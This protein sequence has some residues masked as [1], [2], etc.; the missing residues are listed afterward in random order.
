MRIRVAHSPDSD[1]AFMFHA[2]ANR[3]LDTGAYE[4]VNVLSDIE[5]L[6]RKALEGEYEVTAVSYHAYACVHRRYAL[7]TAGSSMG[8]NYG[9][10]IV[11]RPGAV[12]RA[13][14]PGKLVA[15]PGTLTSAF[16]ALKLFAPEARHEVIPFDRILEHVKAGKSDAGLIIHEGQLTYAEEGLELVADLG[17]WWRGQT[18]LP[19]PLGGNAIRR[20]LGAERMREIGRLLK[21]SIAYGLDHREEALDH[22]QSYGRGLDRGKVDRFV[23][24]YVNARTLDCGPDGREAV[25][26]FLERGYAAGV[27]AEQVTP[28]WV[29][30]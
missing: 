18:Q 1:D 6:N 12:T 7:L 8:E 15:V 9:P 21:A 23:G 29:E 24:M 22:A 26:L 10:M 13:S 4:F 2:L 16:L 20:D 19:L 3:K 28:E 17:V 30:C 14:L 11:A 25:R 5:T 27:I